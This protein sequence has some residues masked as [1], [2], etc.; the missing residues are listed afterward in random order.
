MKMKDLPARKV[1]AA[2]DVRQR[3]TPAETRLWAALR[4]NQLGV[5]FRRQHIIGPFV[6]D[7]CGLPARLVIEVDGDI[8]DQDDVRD[9][10]AWRTE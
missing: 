6:V 7:F 10:D 1:A 9:Q 2:R 3:Q 5:P 4:R 8:H